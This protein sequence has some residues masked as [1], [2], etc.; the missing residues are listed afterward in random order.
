MAYD[1]TK[2]DKTVT[3]WLKT[4]CKKGPGETYAG[5]L[6]ESFDAFVV[7]T[8]ALNGSPG[9]VAFGS[10]LTRKKLKKRKACGLTYWLG[11]TLKKP[12]KVSVPRENTKAD[13]TLRMT[14]KRERAERAK[15]DA[16]TKAEE[17]KKRTKEI[18]KRMKKETAERVRSA[19][20]LEPVIPAD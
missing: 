17:R 1:N 16:I 5:D 3:R 10:A 2:L 9:R 7:K 13:D 20:D 18:I 19:G 12:P 15:Q 4:K 11:L 8:N 6:L 14:T